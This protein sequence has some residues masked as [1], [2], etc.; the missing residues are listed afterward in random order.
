MGG[1]VHSLAQKLLNS[2]NLEDSGTFKAGQLCATPKQL[3][4]YSKTLDAGP[5]VTRWL[6]NELPLA[7]HLEFWNKVKLLRSSTKLSSLKCPQIIQIK[8]I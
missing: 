4:F 1:D 2:F 3:E 6:T 5:M 7:L 8:R